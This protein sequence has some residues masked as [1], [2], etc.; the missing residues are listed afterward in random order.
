MSYCVKGWSEVDLIFE[1]RV[2]V[3]S[4][5]SDPFGTKHLIKACNNLKSDGI[6]YTRL[7][8]RSI[9]VMICHQ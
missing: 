7:I 8:V 9:D 2:E 5:F 6:V 1:E 3:F 4:Y